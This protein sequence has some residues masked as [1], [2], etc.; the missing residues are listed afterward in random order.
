M[1]LLYSML[2]V[3][4]NLTRGQ[5][6]FF[7][8]IYYEYLRNWSRLSKKY[9]SFQIYWQLVKK[10]SQKEERLT[11]LTPPLRISLYLSFIVIFHIGF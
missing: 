2:G 9:H 4:K 5:H 10:N 11:L 7:M 6:L 8:I 3:R 1:Y